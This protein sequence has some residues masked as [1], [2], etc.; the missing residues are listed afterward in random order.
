M[1]RRWCST[2]TLKTT[3]ATP[4]AKTAASPSF[5]RRRSPT[6][7]A[8]SSVRRWEDLGQIFRSSSPISAAASATSRTRSMSRFAPGAPR[9]STAG[10]SASTAR[11]RKRLS[12]TV[13]AMPSGSTSSRGCIRTARLPPEKSSA[14]PIRAHTRPTGTRSWPRPWARSRRS[15]RAQTLRA[16]PTPSTP[17][18]PLRARCAAT[19]C[20]RPRSRTTQILKIARKLSA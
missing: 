5:P 20:R 18:A 16:M 3:A 17:T 10:A 15:I 14:S 12:P 9:R 7:S 4:T 8:G 19:A 11:A 1:K 13:C 6:S 2:A